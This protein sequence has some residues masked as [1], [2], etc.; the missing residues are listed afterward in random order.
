MAEFITSF[1]NETETVIF[2]AGRISGIFFD[3]RSRL[4]KSHPKQ[5]LDQIFPTAYYGRTAMRQSLIAKPPAGH[6]KSIM[7][8]FLC[9]WLSSIF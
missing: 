7:I 1:E 2:Q 4:L 6:L 3:N 9:Q 5:W 8:M